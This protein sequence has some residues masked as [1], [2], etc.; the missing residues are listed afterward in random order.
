MISDQELVE[1]C[2]AVRMKLGAPVDRDRGEINTDY[3]EGMDL[4]GS[5]NE[6]R[7]N[8][9]DDLH[10]IYT[11]RDGKPALLFKAECTTQPGARYTLQPIN[12]DGAAILD[13]GYQEAW[14]PGLHRG[15]YPALIQTG[16]AV[17]VWRDRSKSYS[18]GGENVTKTGWFGINQH[19]AANAP[20]SDIGGHSAGC[21][22]TRL[23]A[24]HERALAIKKDDP[25][26]KADHSFVFGVCL[27][28]AM[29]VV[30]A[31][32]QL[33]GLPM[34]RPR[35]PIKPDVPKGLPQAVG[36]GATT[37]AAAMTF[38]QEHWL[39]LGCFGLVVGAITVWY[40]WRD[41]YPQAKDVSQ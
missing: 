23:V 31:K 3:I 34:E 13:L 6:N 26:Y 36:G 22:T 8:A 25:R 4:D 1:R 20:R 15:N 17:R 19:H 2:V 35:P 5:T 30:T 33:P 12:D 7:K 14:Q 29:Q 37:W 40:L 41:P 10:V 39:L 16:G 32:S 27:M 24:E 9:F 11:F 18:R 28:T 38:A 21:L